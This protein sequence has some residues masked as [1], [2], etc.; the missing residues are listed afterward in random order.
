M[1]CRLMSTFAIDLNR[2]D[3]S[4]YCPARRACPSEAVTPVPGGYAIDS[5]RCTDC[6]ACVTM[7]PMG[8]VVNS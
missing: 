4:P 8:A 3:A 1:E 6:G 2:C 5:E 7:C